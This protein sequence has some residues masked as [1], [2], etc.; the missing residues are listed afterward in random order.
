[1]HVGDKVLVSFEVTITSINDDKDFGDRSFICGNIDLGEHER[2]PGKRKTAYV[3]GIP[4]S[5]VTR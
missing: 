2:M 1:M 5:T 4:M 3:S